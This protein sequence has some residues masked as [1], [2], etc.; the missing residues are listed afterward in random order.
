MKLASSR[1]RFMSTS[2][3]PP[4]S[5]NVEKAILGAILSNPAILV[6]VAE[7][8]KSEYF[9]LDIHQVIYEVICKLDNDGKNPDPITV[10]EVTRQQRQDI[11]HDYFAELVTNCPITLDINNCANLMKDYHV[12]RNIM[13]SCRGI[14]KKAAVYDGSNEIFLEDIEK[15]F[16]DATE[17]KQTEGLIS[18]EDIMTETLA[19]LDRRAGLQ[20]KLSGVTS[21]FRDLDTMTGGWQ[22]N[23][24]II[25][26]ARPGMG[27]TALALNWIT[28]ALKHGYTTVFFSLEM[29]RTQLMMRLLSTETLI[30]SSKIHNGLITEQEQD[31]LMAGVNTISNLTAKFS[32]DDS[33]GI[34]MSAIRSNCRKFKKKHNK[35]DLIVVDYLQLIGRASNSQQ[36]EN[37]EQQVSEF[38]RGLKA[39][40][41]ELEVPVISLSQLNRSPDSRVDKRPRMSDLRES[42]SIEQDAD[43]V[44]FI[45]RDDYYD[46]SS[47]DVGTAELIIGKNRH[48]PMSTVNVAFH[49]DFVLFQNLAKDDF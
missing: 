32:I 26:A 37:R 6:D 43:L 20:G 21:G 48:G 42:G 2:I 25:L 17:N 34:S 3:L 9:Y 28:N 16:Q 5:L 47:E 45:Y 27:K 4:H 33:S 44:M 46:P 12:R 15:D 24:L 41:K 40:A 23:E 1:S 13:N 19:E 7:I 31:R 49:P 22:Q 14:I 35:L 38:S 30:N 8:V 18:S 29:S 11:S 10:A 39:L 36:Y